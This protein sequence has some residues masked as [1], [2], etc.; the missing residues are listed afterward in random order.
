MLGYRADCKQGP[1]VIA[2]VIRVSHRDDR[3]V[4]IVAVDSIDWASASIS[5]RSDANP[6]HPQARSDG[7]YSLKASL[8][9]SPACLRL[10]LV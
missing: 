3:Q 1:R 4:P 10:L 9:F 2:A 6:R 7:G 5:L 8:T